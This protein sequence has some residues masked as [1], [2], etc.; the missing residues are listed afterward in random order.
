METRICALDLLVIEEDYVAH[1][2]EP[3]IDAKERL[4]GE[5]RDRGQGEF[6]DLRRGHP[7][8][9][10][11]QQPEVGFGPLVRRAFDLDMLS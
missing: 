8:Q 4:V 7:G 1:V 9:A 11:R 2:H 3:G 6:V 5:Q 10:F